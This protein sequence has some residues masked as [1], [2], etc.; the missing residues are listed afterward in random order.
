MFQNPVTVTITVV[1]NYLGT[2]GSTPPPPTPPPGPPPGP[3]ASWLE[4]SEDG[5]ILN[6][7]YPILFTDRIQF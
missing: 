5:Y 6:F 7:S 4:A 1:N 2:G 3:S